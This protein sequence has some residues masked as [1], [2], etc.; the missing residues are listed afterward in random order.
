MK[1]TVLFKDGDHQWVVFGRDEGKPDEIIDTNQYA[2]ISGGETLLI[3]PGG[4]EVF[5][6]FLPELAHFADLSKIKGLMASHQDPD[7][8]SSLS[9]WLE[10]CPE[11]KVYASWLWSSFITH[12][13][14]G[15]SVSVESIPDEGMRLPIGHSDGVQAIPA[16]YCHSSGNFSVFDPRAKILFSGDIGAALLPDQSAPLFVPD[17]EQH[18]QLMEGF[19][20]RWMPSAPA[21]R[22]WVRNARELQPEMICPQHGSIFQGD[23]VG[24]FLDWLEGLD[25][26]SVDP[27]DH[28]LT[29][30]R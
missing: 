16:H 1:S 17:F 21:L 25:I 4:I 5:P 22:A 24:L 30:A 29:L 6:R 10:L 26:D 14:M 3:D 7:V 8:I 28:E 13:C 20:L 19:H 9:L 15:R 11:V 12:F 23:D 18:I 27:M 2:V